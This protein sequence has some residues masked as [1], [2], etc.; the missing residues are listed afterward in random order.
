MAPS[1]PP[2]PA[3]E[4]AQLKTTIERLERQRQALTELQELLFGLT[5]PADLE[6][7]IEAVG[8]ALRTAGVPCE[9]YTLALVD[10]VQEP[11]IMRIH[12]R[13]P[14]DRREYAGVA[15]NLELWRRGKPFYRPDLEAEDPLGER[16]ALQTWRPIRCVLDV[17]FSHGTL[18]LSSA[19]P[20]ALSPED[21][22][23]VESLATTLSAGYRRWDEVRLSQRQ[24]LLS[25]VASRL[26]RSV[27]DMVRVEDAQGLLQ[28]VRLA[29]TELSVPYDHLVVNLLHPKHP[30]AVTRP[31]LPRPLPDGVYDGVRP[32]NMLDAV[33]QSGLPD[34]RPDLEAEDRHAEA[35]GIAR[36]YGVPI[37]AVLDVPF[38]M[39]TLSVNST[40]DY[41]FGA[42]DVIAL[43]TVAESLSQ[44]FRRLGDL[45]AL[46][47]R[48][49]DL[50]R[51]LQV[52]R[53]ETAIR[54]L[55]AGMQA[56]EDL[57]RIAAAIQQ[58]LIAA[59][60]RVDSVGFQI[61]HASREG[62]LSISAAY[63]PEAVRQ[64]LA[65]IQEAEPSPRIRDLGRLHPWVIEVWQSGTTHY[66]PRLPI[67][68]WLP[69]GSVVDVPFSHGTV[70]MSSARPEA[71]S[72]EEI[73]LLERLAA[74]L[75]EGFQRSLDLTERRRA[76]ARVLHLNQ[77]LRAIREVNQLIT[78]EQDRDQLL[79]RACEILVETRGY[80]AA[81]IVETDGQGRV[82]SSHAQALD[83][84]A[85][86]AFASWPAQQGPPCLERVLSHP[87]PLQITGPSD[88]CATC[89]LH[90]SIDQ[91]RGLHMRLECAGS[92]YGALFVC[93]FGGLVAN[94][95]EEAL[96]AELAGDLGFALHQ[97]EQNAEMARQQALRQAEQAVRLQIARMES[98]RDLGQ[99]AA[100]ISRQL[101]ALGIGH[102]T[103]GIEVVN[104]A[105]DDFF[106]VGPGV[107]SGGHPFWRHG[108]DWPRCTDNAESYP[109]VIEVWRHRRP[110]LDLE[111]TA[112][113]LARSLIDVPFSHGTVA[114][115]SRQP[116]AFDQQA[117]DAVQR[118]ADVLSEGFLRC[119]DLLR[120]EQSEARLRQAER[121]ETV[122]RLAGGVAHDIN[123]VLTVINGY[124]EMLLRRRLDPADPNRAEVEEILKAGRQAAGVVRQLLAFSRQQ[125]LEPREI[126]LNQVISDTHSLLVRLVGE[127]ITVELQ[128][129]SSPVRV[130]IDPSQIS[131]V[132][133]NL[134]TNGRDAMPDGGRILVETAA[135]ELSELFCRDHAGTRPGPHVRLTVTDEGIGMDAVTQERIFEPFFTTKELSRGTGLGLAMVDG[136]VGQ[137]GG[138]IWVASK[139]GA[140]TR[141][142]IYL[143][144]LPDL[145]SPEPSVPASTARQEPDQYP[146]TVLIAEDEAQ[147]RK[148]LAA[149]L[150][151]A[152][153]TVLTA[154]DGIAAQEVAAGHAGPIDLLLTDLIMP[155]LGGRQLALRLRQTRPELRVLFMSGYSSDPAGNNPG[156]AIHLLTKPLNIDQLLAAIR[157]RLNG[158]LMV[159]ER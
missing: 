23:F 58:E 94:E 51:E 82:Q 129:T 39:G 74:P 150:E 146:E 21:L 115:N 156:D 4:L 111:V 75:S 56:P 140:G 121:L 132:L 117:V 19:R 76:E 138:T 96:F 65:E 122:G 29:L 35:A 80:L 77:V 159:E 59:G 53:A 125:A 144:R 95:E 14:T 26:E 158:P 25:Q 5:A 133:V 127:Q 110:R 91:W 48:A 38:Y 60:V 147:I 66:Q 24:E 88:R 100:E 11:P 114:I 70:A 40:R 157:G 92:V 151:Q 42:D 68:P 71:F 131:E 54:L 32:G 50:E 12:G 106:N 78:R 9:N 135:V 99:V 142:Q 86:E 98:A 145:P 37:R 41:A 118:L 134:V 49:R 87:G 79:N 124:A 90:P 148:L 17:P 143:P 73:A 6:Q 108:V 149:V 120:R 107:V 97:L 52:H 102:D 44:G 136:I 55:V 112:M 13:S 31:H 123:N 34:Y 43:Q 28:A 22:R 8:T 83:P 137:S 85:H 1:A 141:V 36:R 130:R 3:S 72:P 67:S 47:E 153:Y 57:A 61:V 30:A 45:L 62:F 69:G 2:N 103:C 33:W 18:G 155:R 64:Y 104:A 139:P 16:E 152:G 7:V 154:A 46:E 84:T 20:N 113:D 109:W 128:L 27:W 119:L 116:Q 93:L 81:W 89:P 15:A 101:S 10:R 63:P 105:G 126:D